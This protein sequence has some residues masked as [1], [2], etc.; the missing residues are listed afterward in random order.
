[1]LRLATARRREG[2]A[3]DDAMFGA[4]ILDWLLSHSHAIALRGGSCF[5]HRA[6]LVNH[7]SAMREMAANNRRRTSVEGEIS[8]W[9]P[10]SDGAV[11]WLP[12]A[13]GHPVPS[14]MDAT[15]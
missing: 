9:T 4:A 7:A 12:V 6:G 2:G 13:A 15:D 11:A 5:T 14:R 10:R 8:I 3:F 1:M